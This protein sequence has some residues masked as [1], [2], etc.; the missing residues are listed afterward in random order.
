MLQTREGEGVPV[1]DANMP[2]GGPSME[3]QVGGGHSGD[4]LLVALCVICSCSLLARAA[5]KAS[6]GA[7]W[8]PSNAV[9]PSPAP[10]T[11]ASSQEGNLGA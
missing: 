5:C 10:S 6:A 11:W 1:V 4:Q 3:E 7:G 9:P 2:G 8:H